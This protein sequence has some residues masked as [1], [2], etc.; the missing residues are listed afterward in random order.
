MSIYYCKT[1]KDAFLPEEIVTFLNLFYCKKCSHPLDTLGAEHARVSL[2]AHLESSSNTSTDTPGT[3]IKPK[4]YNIKQKDPVL[5]ECETMLAANP[6]N[7]DALFTLSK[8][9]YSHGLTDESQAISKQ[10]LSIDPNHD[11][12][13]TFLSEQAASGTTLPQNVT[14]LE[15]MAINL[16]N[17][18]KL[19]E[20]E[21]IFKKVLTIDPN[22]IAAHRYLTEYYTEKNQHA[23]AIHHLSILT[24][25]IPNDPRILFNLAVACYNAGDMGRAKSNAKAA[26]LYC[27][28][29]DLQSEI[30]AL[31][32]VLGAV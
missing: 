21:P 17:K 24:M 27:K 16:I 20:T 8:W 23:E 1:C 19:N 5:I 29:P 18:G 3:P 2:K 13:H 31:M 22:H 30:S 6:L 7:V 28:E 14:T 9:Y 4:Y 32:D 15:Q 12:A 25:R 11:A 10:I 26:Y